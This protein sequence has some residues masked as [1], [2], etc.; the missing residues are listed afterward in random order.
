MFFFFYRSWD[1]VS[2]ECV[3]AGRLGMWPGEDATSW[4][5]DASSDCLALPDL[6]RKYQSP[7]TQS[8]CSPVDA[9]VPP[10]ACRIWGMLFEIVVPVHRQTYCAPP[11]SLPV[12]QEYDQEDTLLMMEAHRQHHMTV[13][14]SVCVTKLRTLQ[15]KILVSFI[16]FT[17]RSR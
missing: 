11:P 14:F 9:N 2:P 15:P 1:Y 3:Y 6:F 12:P 10:V 13:L 8:L 17:R 4:R 16:L 7:P 5:N